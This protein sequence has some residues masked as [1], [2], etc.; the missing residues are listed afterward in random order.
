MDLV[1]INSKGQLVIPSKIRKEFEITPDS[2]LAIGKLK[3]KIVLKKVDEDL[4]N[5]ITRS[6]E[7]IK[8]G[9]ISEWKD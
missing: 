2:I 3:D 4:L 8:H 6:L 7:D 9:R 1:K 5:Q